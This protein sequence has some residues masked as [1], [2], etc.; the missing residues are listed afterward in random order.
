MAAVLVGA[1]LIGARE[2]GSVPP[3]A[4]APAL[5][6]EPSLFAGI[7]QSGAA[8]G[9]P[10]APVTLVEYADLQCPYCAQWARDALPTLVDDYVRAGKLRIV[11]HGLAFIGPDSNKALRTAVAAGRENHLWDVVHGLYLNQGAENAGW[12]TDTLVQEIVHG[13]PGLEPDRAARRPLAEDHRPGARALRRRGEGRRRQGHARIPGRADGRTARAGRGRVPRSRRDR[14]RDRGG[15]RPMSERSVRIASAV[16]A[17]LGVAI[18]TYLLYVRETGGSLVC[19]TG[20]CETV[21][22]SSYAELLGIP[23]AALGLAGFLVLLVAALARGEWARLT[24]A[25]VA[26]SAFLFAAY[27]LVVQI[28][29]ID[30]ICQWCVA[31]DV[32][33]TA[34]AALAL[35]RLGPASSGRWAP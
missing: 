11:F 15:A 10:A 28:V 16:L 31:T 13:V 19:S 24:N 18:T 26:L 9:S 5:E 27:L 17:S 7:E 3:P 2:D 20:G 4:A 22:S 34:L 30:A 35:V 12:V 8:L 1:S 14:P 6:P 25:T 32:L 23:V 33:T 21:Q 29:V